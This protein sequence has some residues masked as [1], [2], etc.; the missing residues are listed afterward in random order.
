[1]RG[2][3]EQRPQGNLG[4]S[5]AYVF[6]VSHHVNN[7]EGDLAIPHAKHK[8]FSGRTS[9]DQIFYLRLLMAVDNKFPGTINRN[10]MLRV[11]ESLK[12]KEG[13]VLKWTEPGKDEDIGQ[14]GGENDGGLE[15]NLGWR[16][17]LIG[18]KASQTKRPARSEDKHQTA[19]SGRQR[20][21]QVRRS[22]ER[23]QSL[24][25]SLPPHIS[26]PSSLKITL[27]A[28]HSGSQISSRSY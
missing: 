27:S 17:P 15:E 14:K 2:A 28:R 18:L 16:P 9:S 3:G 5:T 8:S 24:L 26:P 6:I 4:R 22:L 13:I 19:L 1:M 11:R 20:G 23:A 21:V 25:P 7:I 12:A 10:S